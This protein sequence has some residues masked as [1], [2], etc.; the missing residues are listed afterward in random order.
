MNK[1]KKKYT[2]LGIMMVAKKRDPNNEN[3]PKRFYIKLEQQ[4]TKD[5]K[6][7]GEQ[8]FPITLANGMVLKDG[9]FLSMFSKKE[10]L[11]E[12][13]EDGKLDQE[14]ADYLSSFLLFDI[15]AVE[16]VDEGNDGGKG[17]IEF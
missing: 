15:V 11:Q 9:D 4:K 17:G 6:P 10:K 14:R 8:V 1:P 3:E 5:G 16:E 13:V 7:Y 2:N 12:L